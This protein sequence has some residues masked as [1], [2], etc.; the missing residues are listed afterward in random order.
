VPREGRVGSSPTSGTA[1][2]R[3]KSQLGLPAGSFDT[4]FTLVAGKDLCGRRGAQKKHRPMA[5]S[6]WYVARPLLDDRPLQP[7]VGLRPE[8]FLLILSPPPVLGVPR[9][10]RLIRRSPGN[11][12][13]CG[14]S[15]VVDPTP[16]DVLRGRQDQPLAAVALD[17][18]APRAPDVRLPVGCLP[19]LVASLC[20]VDQGRHPAT[21]FP[22]RI[23]GRHLVC[24]YY[25][26]PL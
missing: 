12:V 3:R 16:A 2:H 18:G 26:Y 4:R 21:P 20:A 11:R 23:P 10:G 5:I 25:S 7:V 14:E 13:S 19:D 9:M 17:H 1:S 6:R 8:V 15:L 24:Y 22:Q